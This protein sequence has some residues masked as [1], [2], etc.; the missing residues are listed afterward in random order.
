MPNPTEV[1]SHLIQESQEDQ[2][3]RAVVIRLDTNQA[4]VRR[5]GSVTGE[6]SYPK[7]DGLTLVAGDEVVVARLGAGYIILCKVLRNT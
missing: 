2:L 4:F 5:D 7:A 3:F 1:V 6:G